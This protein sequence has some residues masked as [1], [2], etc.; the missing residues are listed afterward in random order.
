MRDTSK[1][2]A[3]CDSVHR[4]FCGTMKINFTK[5]RD[6]YHSPHLSVVIA[7]TYGNYI[8]ISFVVLNFHWWIQIHK[9]K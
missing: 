2:L 9:K 1:P 7:K 8:Q 5:F 3:P 4:G 6:V